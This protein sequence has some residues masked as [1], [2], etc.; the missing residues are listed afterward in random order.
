MNRRT[1]FLLLGLLTVTALLAL[2]VG[3]F[4]ADPGMIVKALHAWV[5]GTDLPDPHEQA[6][7]SMMVNVRL[8]RIM[9]AL[10]IGAALATSGTV[11]QAMFLNPLVSPGILGVLAGASF[12]AALGI[13]VF[14]SWLATQV[15][16]FIF[17]ALAVCMSLFFA[18]FMRKSSLLVLILGGMISTS[19]FT[20]MTALVKFV[21]DQ[22]RQL[23]ELTYWL[24][25]TFSRIDG[26]TLVTL[27][28][29]M[30]AGI[31][32]LCMHGKI[33][34]ALS[35]GD[36]EAQSMGVPVRAMRMRIIAVATCISALTVVLV[37]V[38]GWVGLVIPHILR[39]LVG[40]DN[41][42]LLPAAAIG[43]A[44]FMMT[45]DMLARNLFT[46]EL[47]IGVFTSLISLPIF[48]LSL[49]F[50]KGGWR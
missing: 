25:G 19:F 21:A 38:V 40:P 50:S 37:G 47:P 36:E 3:R 41:R 45:T 7:V 20:S 34:N 11:Y 28:I 39:F 23:P 42:V 16:A 44:V 26:L 35:M 5:S 18:A 24:M 14:S 27:G 8:P 4:S 12:G 6:V 22:E 29:P 31:I 15:L 46:A 43:G 1:L 30:L 10:I 2:F 17:A 32:F 33:I 13:V 9:A 49:R 48:I